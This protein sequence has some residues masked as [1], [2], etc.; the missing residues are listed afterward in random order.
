[1]LISTN[2]QS[3]AAITLN[4][5]PAV[6][7]TTPDLPGDDDEDVPPAAPEMLPPQGELDDEDTEEP[8]PFPPAPLPPA[9]LD[10]APP[11]RIE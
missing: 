2:V 9:T 7:Y 5:V 1:M 4:A 10:V 11:A 3:V 6:L 8:V